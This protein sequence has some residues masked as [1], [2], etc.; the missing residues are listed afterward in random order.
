MKKVVNSLFGYH[1]PKP[2]EDFTDVIYTKAEY[3]EN[4]RKISD[5]EANIKSLEK[6]YDRRI[7]IYKK[8]ANEKAAEIRTQADER[9]SAAQTETEKHKKRA[10]NFENANKNLIRVATE[11]ANAQRGLTPKKQHIGYVFLN[12]E[13]YVYNCECYIAEKSDKTKVLKLPCFRFR[14]QSPYQVS[15]DLEA[16]KNLIESDFKNKKIYAMLG[17]TKNFNIVDWI[18]KELI[19]FWNTEKDNFIFK[20]F[21]KENFQKG[22]LEAEYLTR[23]MPVIPQDMIASKK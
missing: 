22:F 21:Y 13:E 20:I 12:A 11:R 19:N 18:E 4:I 14:L 16:A 6:D 10:D 15:F 23:F 3:Y 9:I 1:E 5:L 7:A 8:S 2:D 17:I